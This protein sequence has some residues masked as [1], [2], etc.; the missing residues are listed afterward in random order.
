MQARGSCSYSL[1]WSSYEDK[2]CLH[3]VG[4]RAT[5]LKSNYA[6]PRLQEPSYGVQELANLLM[7]FYGLCLKLSD[8]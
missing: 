6:S 3:K 7:A 4:D 2:D 5:P 8:E 1:T